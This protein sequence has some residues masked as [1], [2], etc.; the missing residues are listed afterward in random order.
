MLIVKMMLIVMVMLRKIVQLNAAGVTGRI[1]QLLL[2]MKLM[3]R[4]WKSEL[5]KLTDTVP[6][7][8]NKTASDV[9]LG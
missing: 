5:L 1:Q 4:R 7:F 8:S 2:M 9:L 6:Q 3:R